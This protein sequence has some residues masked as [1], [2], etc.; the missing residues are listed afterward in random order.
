MNSKMS[1]GERGAL[2]WAA[3]RIR[4]DAVTDGVEVPEV[5]HDLFSLHGNEGVTRLC[6]IRNALAYIDMLGEFGVA[7]RALD[8]LIQR[9]EAREEEIPPPPFA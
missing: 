2:D 6:T 1:P 4:D 3:K 5:A 8:R 9:A 7:L